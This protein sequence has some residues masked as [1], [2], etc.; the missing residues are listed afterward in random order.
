MAKHPQDTSC[1]YV[2]S[3]DRQDGPLRRLRVYLKEDPRLFQGGP[4]LRSGI[5][6]PRPLQKLSLKGDTSPSDQDSASKEEI[7]GSQNYSLQFVLKHWLRLWEIHSQSSIF[8][9]NSYTT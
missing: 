1:R 6:S 9:R 7:S 8:A 3:E 2:P 4:L 5:T